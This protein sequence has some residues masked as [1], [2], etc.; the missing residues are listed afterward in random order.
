MTLLEKYLFCLINVKESR[1]SGQDRPPSDYGEIL[2]EMWMFCS[3]G[4][5]TG[6]E[7]RRGARRTRGKMLGSIF[8]TSFTACS[9]LGV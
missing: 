5:T 3:C 2:T 8:D 1:R 7:G 9:S 6:E 4:V